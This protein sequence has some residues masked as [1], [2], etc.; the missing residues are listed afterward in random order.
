MSVITRQQQEVIARYG[1]DDCDVIDGGI[2]VCVVSHPT[3]SA[4]MYIHLDGSIDVE[5]G[6]SLDGY[7]MVALED[8]FMASRF[9]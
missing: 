7:E 3:G 6:D 5:E 1:L 9:R 8:S 4:D 2:V